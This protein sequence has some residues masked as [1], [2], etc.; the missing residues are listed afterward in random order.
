[1]TEPLPRPR[2]ASLLEVRRLRLIEDAAPRVPPAERVAMDRLWEE[3]VQANPCLFDGPVAA[4]A[5]LDQDGPHS[6][7]LT[8]ARTTYRHR[9][10]RWVP[11]ATSW[12]PSLFVA[13]AQPAT[14]DG[15][16]LVGRM[17]ASTAT[18]GRW[19]LPGGAVEPPAEG[20]GLDTAALRS[21]AARELAEETGLGTAPSD[22]SLWLVTRGE[23]GSVGVVFLA[24]HQPTSLLRERFAALTSAEAAQG[25]DPEL[26]RIAFIRSPAEVAGLKDACVDYLAPLVRHYVNSGS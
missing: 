2:E 4:C 9:A 7:V 3:A 25:R 23:N 15:S 18:P 21:H 6:V 13:V 14:D 12:L 8:W 22:L 11:G 5:G 17:S 16:L 10:L 20:A 1:M 24:P 26:E 19:Q